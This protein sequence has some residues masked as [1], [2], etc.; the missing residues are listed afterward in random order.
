MT[1]PV[2]NQ[3]L[4]GLHWGQGDFPSSINGLGFRVRGTFMGPGFLEE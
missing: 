2:S 3:R 1:A 4:Y